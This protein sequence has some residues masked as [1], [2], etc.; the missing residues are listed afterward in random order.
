MPGSTRI[1]S[2]TKRIIVAV[3]LLFSVFATLLVV[4]QQRRA[5]VVDDKQAVAENNLTTDQPVPPEVDTAPEAAPVNVAVAPEEPSEPDALL[6]EVPSAEGG[7]LSSTESS[8][9]PS[10]PVSQPVGDTLPELPELEFDVVRVTPDGNALVAGRA[11]PGA[12]VS[13][14]VDGVEVANVPANNNGKFALSFDLEPSAAPRLMT[15]STKS[16]EGEVVESTESVILSPV[17]AP[18][19]PEPPAE[20]SV[21]VAEDE[22]ETSVVEPVPVEDTSVASTESEVAQPLSNQ[23]EEAEP[24]DTAEVTASAPQ[25]PAVL[26]ADESGVRVL[27]P[28]PGAA[29]PEGVSVDAIST[30]PDGAMAISGRAPGGGFVRLYADNAEVMTVPI[31]ST[32]SWRAGLPQD[33]AAQFVLR[34]DQLDTDGK[35]LARTETDVARETREQLDGLLV[36]EVRAGSTAAVVVTVQ[37]GFT[38]WAIARENYGD[39]RLYVKVFEAN[40]EQIR[41]PDLIYPG[42][43]F[44]IPSEAFDAD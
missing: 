42:Q 31:D 43:T 38:L 24:A 6:G 22:G 3:I 20:D 28:E 32:G 5:S 41:D 10:V 33:L 16:S 36:E 11:D 4:V 2:K 37:E 19:P 1:T 14:V 25:A 13:I 30:N 17:V 12:Q 23:T 21:A 29:I 15:L 9:A 40:R 27:Q 8:A 26:L 39:G 44:T 7:D 34:V 18:K 35:V